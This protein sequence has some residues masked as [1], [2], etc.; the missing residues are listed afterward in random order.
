MKKLVICLLFLVLFVSMVGGL[1]LG[2]MCIGEQLRETE[3]CYG[4]PL[5]ACEESY[6][7]SSYS[8]AIKKGVQCQLIDE[9][10]DGMD[11][12][13]Y[14][15]DVSGSEDVCNMCGNREVDLDWGEECD[16]GMKN[17]HDKCIDNPD[18]PY[19]GI[20]CKCADLK[21][22]AVE[23]CPTLY[24]W[25]DGDAECSDYS[26]I[27][28]GTEFRCEQDFMGRF[29]PGVK[30]CSVDYHAGRVHPCVLE[31]IASD[32]SKVAAGESIKLTLREKENC[33][34]MGF[35]PPSEKTSE[36]MYVTAIE[37][38]G[39]FGSQEINIKERLNYKWARFDSDTLQFIINGLDCE[40]SLFEGSQCEYKIRVGVEGEDDFVETDTIYV[41]VGETVPVGAG[42][43]QHCRNFEDCSLLLGTEF[44]NL[45]IKINRKH[46]GEPEDINFLLKKENAHN[47]LW[48]QDP[49]RSTDKFIS[50]AYLECDKKSGKWIIGAETG[51][52]CKTKKPRDVPPINIESWEG[53]CESIKTVKRGVSEEEQACTTNEDCGGEQICDGATG[54]CVDKEKATSC[55]KPCSNEKIDL[56]VSKVNPSNTKVPSKTESVLIPFSI[57][58]SE[59]SCKY[60]G[61]LRVIGGHSSGLIECIENED[62]VSWK[63]STSET[64]KQNEFC[65]ADVL[66]NEISPPKKMERWRGEWCKPKD[67]SCRLGAAWVPVGPVEEK[68][69]VGLILK[70]TNCKEHE[71]ELVEFKIK[72]DDPLFDE[73]AKNQPSSQEFENGLA[74]SFWDAE[75]SPDP[76]AIFG[77]KDPEYYFRAYISGKKIKSQKP[78]LHV[79]KPKP[80]EVVAEPEPEPPELE[81]PTPS[82]E[83]AAEEKIEKDPSRCKGKGYWQGEWKK[84]NE[85][86]FDEEVDKETREIIG[87]RAADVG[88]LIEAD[89]ASI[90]SE[91]CKG[92]VIFNIYK[93]RKGKD[94]EGIKVNEELTTTFM[95][96]S[97][98]MKQGGNT[99]EILNKI[100]KKGGMGDYYF[101]AVLEKEADNKGYPNVV[102]KSDVLTIKEK[103]VTEKTSSIIG[104]YNGNGEFEEGDLKYLSTCLNLKLQTKKCVEVFDEDND[105]DV[106]EKDFHGLI[107]CCY[108]ASVVRCSGEE[109]CGD[110]EVCVENKCEGID[111]A[112]GVGVSGEEECEVKDAYFAYT[113]SWPVGEEVV[114]P[115][116]DLNLVVFGNLACEEKKAYYVVNIISDGL[117]FQDSQ[118]PSAE[119]KK[120]S[121]EGTVA[122]GSWKV[123]EVEEGIE[124]AYFKVDISELSEEAYSDLYKAPT[125][126]VIE[127][128]KIKIGDVECVSDS[129]CK[130]DK[131]CCDD[132]KCYNDQ[133]KETV[134]KDGKKYI[135]QCTMH[136]APRETFCICFDFDIYYDVSRSFTDSFTDSTINTELFEDLC[137]NKAWEQF[138][139]PPERYEEEKELSP[140]ESEIEALEKELEEINNCPKDCDKEGC[141]K[142]Y[143]LEFKLDSLEDKPFA[144]ILDRKDSDCLWVSGDLSSVE[145]LKNLGKVKVSCK[146]KNLDDNKNE[147]VLSFEN[148]GEE[149]KAYSEENCPPSGSSN[150]ICSDGVKVITFGKITIIEGS[151]MME[152][153]SE[154]ETIDYTEA[155]ESETEWPEVLECGAVDKPNNCL[156]CKEVTHV[157]PGIPFVSSGVAAGKI[158]K[159]FEFTPDRQDHEQC[160][161]CKWCS[162]YIAKG[163][164]EKPVY[165]SVA[166]DGIG[167]DLGGVGG[168]CKDGECVLAE[169]ERDKDCK[170]YCIDETRRQTFDCV[171]GQCVP[172]EIEDGPTD[173][174]RFLRIPTIKPKCINGKWPLL[175]TTKE[176]LPWF[177][178]DVPIE[179]PV[180][181]TERDGCVDIGSCTLLNSIRAVNLYFLTGKYPL[182]K[183]R[184]FE[185]NSLRLAPGIDIGGYRF[186]PKLDKCE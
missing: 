85:V 176:P 107:Q 123:P 94:P 147:W 173:L 184:I 47:C 66:E 3:S 17:A 80:E 54:T 133:M 134:E 144:I 25:E 48:T 61:P 104:D 181:G 175:K 136:K 31:S 122:K 174:T 1:V 84:K 98:A 111:G 69:S 99:I 182:I 21:Y 154:E 168:I 60:T 75:Y 2:K 82:E 7:L 110:N 49:P 165:T 93:V 113:N 167:C 101:S 143:F 137:I 83:V 103:V 164:S 177:K 183:I 153:E 58:G 159:T 72:E 118:T 70:G 125:E 38:D 92:K 39:L 51:E 171:G 59:S 28:H 22:A 52:S 186:G 146:S 33:Y 57:T 14:K 117:E 27:Y 102:D 65:V 67:G 4:V 149:C 71:G 148:I 23:E 20:N 119:F 163:F 50:L 77:D 135:K 40:P 180:P 126:Y 116:T 13:C 68:S 8:A 44:K 24:S 79:T 170:S 63:F 132:K 162:P 10:L 156:S 120:R 18:K 178:I 56:L 62:G 89:K 139:C 158:Y 64:R 90:K 141:S 96:G 15:S 81:E 26:V 11:D 128:D 76:V 185:K 127:S 19:C 29:S 97:I 106:D 95:G 179:I 155:I 112:E 9:D 35:Y 53:D 105:G 30:K 108:G 138:E 151:A 41:S 121:E 145:E 6:I 166:L 150:W 172:G 36:E 142:D 86:E 114:E 160:Y 131:L 152:I 115:K 16:I 34:W 87:V 55:P 109:D 169:C 74:V 32:K 45:K 100:F 12:S 37:S 43:I 73:S 161:E 46:D 88:L 140:H 5:E 129:D 78:N 130:K 42:K 91:S 157:K 124:E